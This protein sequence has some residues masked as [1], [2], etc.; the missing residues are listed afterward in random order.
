MG[1]VIQ[2]NCVEQPRDDWVVINLS[3]PQCSIDCW[4]AGPEQRIGHDQIRLTAQSCTGHR[5]VIRAEVC[6]QREAVVC[7]AGLGTLRA[8][9]RWQVRDLFAGHGGIAHASGPRELRKHG[10]RQAFLVDDRNATIS[11]RV[12]EQQREGQFAHGEGSLGNTVWSVVPV[13]VQLDAQ[14]CG[15]LAIDLIKFDVHGVAIQQ[16]C[17]VID[18]VPHPGNERYGAQQLFVVLCAGQTGYAFLFFGRHFCH[19]CPDLSIEAAE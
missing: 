12:G 7:L 5:G 13:G 8:F 16:I 15:A 14:G 1:A 19:L 10:I 18:Q 6:G 2:V 11:Q 4:P 9:N 3:R 17:R